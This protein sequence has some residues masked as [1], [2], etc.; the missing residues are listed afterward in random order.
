MKLKMLLFKLFACY[1]VMSAVT[2]IEAFINRTPSGLID[3]VF[4]MPITF[5]LVPMFTLIVLEL[6]KVPSSTA[7]TN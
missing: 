2:M 1:F 4:A 3:R 5:V 6:I 7:K